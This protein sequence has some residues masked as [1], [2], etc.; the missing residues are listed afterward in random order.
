MARQK[1]G[2]DRE[3]CPYVWL[4]VK[5]VWRRWPDRSPKKARHIRHLRHKHQARHRDRAM[6]GE[7]T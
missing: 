4:V 1:W 7:L 2:F 6:Q 3:R 5:R